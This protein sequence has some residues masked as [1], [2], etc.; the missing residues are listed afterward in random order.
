ML[1]YSS[2][3]AKHILETNSSSDEVYLIKVNKLTEALSLE[4]ERCCLSAGRAVTGAHATCSQNFNN[5]E[6]CGENGPMEANN[7]GFQGN[8]TVMSRGLKVHFHVQFSKSI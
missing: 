7:M 2:V 5:T 4:K 3:P 8:S 6:K 1:S